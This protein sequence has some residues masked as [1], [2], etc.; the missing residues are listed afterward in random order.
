MSCTPKNPMVLLI[1]I[2]TKWLFHWG[3]TP[4]SD[5]PIWSFQIHWNWRETHW[6]TKLFLKQVQMHYEMEGFSI[7]I[8]ISVAYHV[9]TWSHSINV[10]PWPFKKAPWDRHIARLELKDPSK[11]WGP[12]GRFWEPSLTAGD[13]PGQEDLALWRWVHHWRA[14]GTGRMVCPC[15]NFSNFRLGDTSLHRRYTDLARVRRLQLIPRNRR[16]EHRNRNSGTPPLDLG[17]TT[18]VSWCFQVHKWVLK[19]FYKPSP[20]YFRISSFHIFLHFFPIF[21]H[22][23]PYFPIFSHLK[24][25]RQTTQNHR[26]PRTL[27]CHAL[28]SCPCWMVPRHL[29]N[30]GPAPGR[31]I[32]ELLVIAMVAMVVV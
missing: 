25:D 21:P 22:I 17:V 32:S 2:P 23:S 3:Y 6:N 31:S 1:I 11:V 12:R 24:S 14:R 13:L 19:W 4:F 10:S 8:S 18:M 20:A 5:I 7:S 30:A 29:S 27:R 16:R 26:I 28:S 15:F 9:A